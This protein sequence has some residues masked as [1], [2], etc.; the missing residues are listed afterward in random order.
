M[1]NSLQ[2]ARFWVRPY[3]FEGDGSNGAAQAMET[4][5]VG[6]RERTF[7]LKE[8]EGRL[9]FREVG[10][11]EEWNF[12]S[13]EAAKLSDWVR[14]LEDE[15][16]GRVILPLEANRPCLLFVA[17]NR[18]MVFLVPNSDVVAFNFWRMKDLPQDLAF[19]D[20]EMDVFK[21]LWTDGIRIAGSSGT[22]KGHIRWRMNQLPIPTVPEMWIR[23]SQ[24]EFIKLINSFCHL[25]WDE[26]KSDSRQHDLFTW[27][28][29]SAWAMAE[30]KFATG[31]NF[32]LTL[33]RG[34]QMPEQLKPKMK[35]LLEHF[36]WVGQENINNYATRPAGLGESLQAPTFHEKIEAHRI[37]KEWVS[38][39]MAPDEARDWLNFP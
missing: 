34:I 23:G 9:F 35:V 25:F 31:D 7:W 28:L 2:N 32:L 5:P 30:M 39:K 13:L 26:L 21:E 14:I 15:N 17:A 20:W 27:Q 22:P 33:R 18:K 24:N 11:G 8:L 38:D 12:G 6:G 36:L 19:Y 37:L 3:E 16:F 29:D 4:W 10:R 1:S